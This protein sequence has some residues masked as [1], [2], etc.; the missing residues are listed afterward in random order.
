M[1]IYGSII[2]WS[3]DCRPRWVLNELGIP[4]E[5]IDGNLFG[6]DKPADLLALNPL[7]RVPTMVDGDISAHESGALV[8]Y[9]AETYGADKLVP[10]AGGQRALYYQ[11]IFFAAAT[12]EPPS[13]QI[14]VNGN[15]LKDA[16]G[17]KERLAEGK[18]SFHALTPA[19]LPALEK[20][21]YVLGDRFTAA[22]IMIGSTLHWAWMGMGLAEYPALERYH[23][24]VSERPAFKATFGT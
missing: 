12:L 18:K 20:G 10:P 6:A 22:D 17:A 9:L 2:K 21:P 16:D 1:K 24:L 5:T 7:G 11:W 8:T 23:K 13:V 4:F 15:M 3:R 19:L 14:L